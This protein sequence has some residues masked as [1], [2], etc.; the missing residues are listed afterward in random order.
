MSVQPETKLDGADSITNRSWIEEFRYH[1]SISRRRP[2]VAERSL[3]KDPVALSR[4]GFPLN[5]F[6]HREAVSQFVFVT[7]ADDYYIYVSL[8]AIARI[9]SLF[10]NH[11][12]YFYDLSDGVLVN[13]VDTVLLLLLIYATNHASRMQRKSCNRQGKKM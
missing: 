7:A 9:Q 5:N 2:L 10:P 8:D 12:I 11:S 13:K 6:T 1:V 3:Y 4:L